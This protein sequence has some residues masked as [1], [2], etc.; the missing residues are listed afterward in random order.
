MNLNLALVKTFRWSAEFVPIPPP[1]PPLNCSKVGFFLSY[2]VDFCRIV[3]KRFPH[4]TTV[5]RNVAG[6]GGSVVSDEEEGK[7]RASQEMMGEVE[8]ILEWGSICKQVSRF[9]STDTGRILCWN[10]GIHVGRDKTESEML[11]DQ[12]EAALRLPQLLDF[13]GI[14]DISDFVKL[15]ASG[16]ILTVRELCIVE[17]TLRSVRRVYEQLKIFSDHETCDD[18]SP[19]LELFKD[20]SFV[21]DWVQKIG[22][23]INKNLLVILDQASS[24]LE[25]IRSEKRQNMNNLEALLKSV[26]SRIFQAGGIDSPLVTR[27]RSRMCVGIRASHKSLLPNSILVGTSSSGATYFMEPRNVMELNNMEVQLSNSEQAEEMAILSKLTSELVCRKTEVLH[28]MERMLDL[29][30]ACARGSHARWMNAIRPSFSGTGDEMRLNDGKEVMMVDIENICHPLLLE[31]SLRKIQSQATILVQAD[32][33]DGELSE[34]ETVDKTVVVPLDIKIKHNKKVVVISGPNTGGKTV[35]MKTLGLAAIMSKAGLFLPCTNQPKLPWFDRLLADIGD[36]QSLEHNLSTFSGHVSRLCK[37]L[38]AA[39]TESLVLIDEIGNG[40]DPSEGVVLSISILQYLVHRVGL[41]VVTTHYAD[42]SLLKDKDSRFENAAM[43]FCTQTLKPTYRILWGNI[44]KS[45]ALSIAK[46]IGFDEEIIRHAHQWVKNLLPDKR[47]ERHGLLY[48]SLLEERNKLE[49]K[50]KKANSVLL[51]VRRLH[52]E[53]NSEVVDLA[54]RETILKSNETKK[55]NDEVKSVKSQMDVVVKNF[56]NQL[57]VADLTEFSKLTRQTESSIASIV[58]PYRVKDDGMLIIEEESSRMSANYA[59]NAGDQVVVKKLGDM[60][61]SVVEGLG[62]D[63]K[64][65]IQYGKFR[66]RVKKSEV[67]LIKRS[68]KND[69]KK[70]VSRNKRNVQSRNFNRFTKEEESN[71][72]EDGQVSYGATVQT[73]K[74]T[75]DLRGMRMEEASNFLNLAIS[76]CRS[77]GVLFVVH[78]MGT[79]TIKECA[80]DILRKNSRVAK[81]EPENPMNHGCTVVYVK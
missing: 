5:A 29:D 48:Q 77:R 71:K 46:S 72:E 27:R 65:Q 3:P 63:G 14:D 16:D 31:P 61:A 28:L 47:K 81:F 70:M 15:A 36:H 33:K 11:L 60:S 64:I 54:T 35:S 55:V 34:D 17:Q 24:K 73:S 21:E 59:P 40:T 9:A 38:D 4:A 66:I 10:G 19:L 6:F 51:E 75:V 57:K 50:A 2:H 79:G 74:N 62:D 78:G 30:M 80:Y 52:D 18:Y 20:C 22:M 42:L 68:L 43:E 39:T 45:N 41:A 7:L 8:D 69:S 49:A 53:I 32:L 76:G 23:C 37:I 56:E 25:S 44:G 1:P 67:R 12:T 26:S 58:E 13:S